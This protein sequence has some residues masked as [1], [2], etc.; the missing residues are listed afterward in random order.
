MH[1]HVMQKVTVFLKLEQPRR[2]AIKHDHHVLSIAALAVSSHA[3]LTIA[4]R[5]TPPHWQ[6][7]LFSF[8]SSAMSFLRYFRLTSPLA[9]PFIPLARMAPQLDPMCAFYTTLSIQSPDVFIEP[10]TS[11]LLHQDLACL[12]FC[13]R[14]AAPVQAPTSRSCYLCYIKPVGYSAAPV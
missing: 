6:S 2:M 11:P 5:I 7:C 3:L 8:P 14:H 12:T 1:D 13:F 9:H 10:H 4:Q